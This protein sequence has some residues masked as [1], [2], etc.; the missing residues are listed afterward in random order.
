MTACSTK[1]TGVSFGGRIGPTY[2]GPSEAAYCSNTITHTGPTVNVTGTA[3]YIRRNPWGDLTAGGL[4]SSDLNHATAAYRATAH[5]IRR[6][7]VVV[8]DTNTG[9]VVQCGATLNNGT[10]S[11]AVP[12]SGGPY[13]ISVNSRIHNA[14]HAYVSVLNRPELNKFYSLTAEVTAGAPN[15]GTMTA[16]ADGNVLGGAFSILDQILAANEYLRNELESCDTDFPGCTGFDANTSAPYVAVYWEKG[17]NPNSYFGGS[18]GLSFYMPGYSR[19][20]ILGGSN[21]DTDNFDTDH[22]DHSI[23]LH[24]YGH[25]LE[26]SMF[27]SDSPGGSHNGNGVIDPRLAWSEGWG[28]FFQAA[29]TGIPYYI[30]TEGNIDGSAGVNSTDFFFYRDIESHTLGGD[31]PSFD[32]EGHFREF[33][34]A[35][36]LWDA[37]DSNGDSRAGFTD[38]ISGAFAELWAT[39]T[40]TTQGFRNSDFAFRNMGTVHL[41]QTW[42]DANVGS[43]TTWTQIRGVNRHIA[44]SSDYAQYVEPGV[45]ADY[46]YSIDPPYSSADDGS[47]STSNL[48]HNNDFYHLKITS[49][50]TYNFQLIHRNASG[51]EDVKA[52]LDLYLYDED[53]R[54]GYGSDIVRYSIK[55]TNGIVLTVPGD[56]STRVS[57]TESFSVKL[58]PGEY[59]IQ[60][61]LYSGETMHG[62]SC[63]SGPGQSCPAEYTL[64]F[65]ENSQPTWSNLCPASLV[66]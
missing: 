54:I 57:E 29:V 22:F 1:L 6:A 9:N 4:G 45:C 51:F 2:Q 26:D 7:E 31:I 21:G 66:P 20:F 28:N 25:F 24:E 37:T 50:A 36:L 65:K 11:L 15:A 58:T 47:M 34:V 39:L 12:Q 41:F 44:D 3:R 64:K 35:R 62:T 17:F 55:E 42:L 56:P 61:N 5:A 19:I 32:G 40:K 30:D 38:N 33:A 46:S 23:V 49:T 53:A 16:T 18:G 63:P 27:M 8:T 13:K 10:F 14:S 52:D 59:L 43:A 48:F 60:V